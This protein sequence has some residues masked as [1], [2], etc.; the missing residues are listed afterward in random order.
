MIQNLGEGT[1]N[2]RGIHKKSGTLADIAADVLGRVFDVFLRGNFESKGGLGVY[3]TPSP[4]K[5]AML[6]IGFHDIEKETPGIL[7]ARD[8]EGKPAFRFCDPACGS[9]GFGVVAMGHLERALMALLG[10]DTA[11]DARRDN[12]FQEMCE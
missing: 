2:W 12:L 1:D 5:R 4:V 9:Y 3:L 10:K 7:T 11:P 6:A 8:E